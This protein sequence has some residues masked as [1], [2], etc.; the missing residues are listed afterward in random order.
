M[1]CITAALLLSLLWASPASAVDCAARYEKSYADIW[2]L[3]AGSWNAA[4]RKGREAAE[5]L[6]SAQT[7]FIRACKK[8][9]REP[10][11]TKRLIEGTV[12]AYCAQGV[13]GRARL[14]RQMGMPLVPGVPKKKEAV[15]QEGVPGSGGMGP[16]AAAT[17]IARS[18]WGDDLCLSAMGYYWVPKVL[19][20]EKNPGRT[21][22]LEPYEDHIEGFRYYFHSHNNWQESFVVRFYDKIDAAFNILQERLQGPEMIAGIKE[23][24]QDCLRKVDTE[25]EAAL[26]VANKHGLILGEGSGYQIYL[27]SPETWKENYEKCLRGLRKGLRFWCTEALSRRQQRKLRGK[28]LWVVISEGKTAFVNA[29]DGEFLFLSGAKFQPLRMPELR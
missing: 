3:N 25:P 6:R 14:L 13:R 27:I 16:M 1:P 12:R 28:E 29:E 2:E 19:N 23:T 26:T 4:C 8:R 7:H 18:K 17:R 9:F 21:G 10:L 22:D 24:G 11:K 15:S 5:I 20:K